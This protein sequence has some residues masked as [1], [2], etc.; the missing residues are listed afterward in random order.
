[1]PYFLIS[2]LLASLI[3]IKERQ[4]IQRV[5]DGYGRETKAQTAILISKN[6][7][8]NP[9]A[10]HIYTGKGFM[11]PGPRNAR[12]YF[13]FMLPDGTTDTVETHYGAYISYCEGNVIQAAVCKGRFSGKQRVVGFI[14]DLGIDLSHCFY[15]I[16]V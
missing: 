5:F 7:T 2:I 12:Y 6:S 8:E 14:K 16:E 11:R 15:E 9:N 4:Y 13:T 10:R 3:C 1:M